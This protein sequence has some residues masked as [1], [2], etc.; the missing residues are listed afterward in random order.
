LA[1]IGKDINKVVE[2]LS[3]SELVGLP[4]ETVY[5][6]A[7]NAYNAK[8]VAKIFKVKARPSF[9]PLIVHTSAVER[10]K[11]FVDEIPDKAEELGR[12]FWPG[13]L[14]MV[15]VKKPVIPHLVT[16]G[17]NTV[18]VRIPNHPLT[19]QLLD[20]LEFPLAAPSAN[21][22]GYISPTSTQHVNEQLGDKISYILDGGNCRIGIE[23]TILS[24]DGDS[25]T[26]L[27]LGGCKIEEIEAIVGKVEV[28]L[29]TTS[30]PTAPGMLES[31]YAPFTGVE[32][33]DIDE[34]IQKYLGQNVGVLSFYKKH[35]GVPSG[36]QF[37]LSEKADLE[38]AA[39]R[40][41]TGLRHLDSLNLQLILCEFVPD[42]GLGRAINDRLAR[43]EIKRS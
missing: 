3:N 33:G 17:L 5:G 38:E 27:R 14:T 43:A 12:H 25:V 24:L 11:E 37:V 21:P 9:D 30:N 23:S 22:F 18:A 1:V 36:N 7:G 40:L 10:L 6:L 41:F 16:S 35:K 31:H 13:P 42:E 34:L 39:T 8:A 19:I 26:V 28:K 32:I 20:K 4:T 29:H 15:L 2:L